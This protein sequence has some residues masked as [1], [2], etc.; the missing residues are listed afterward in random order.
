MNAKELISN[1]NMRP[2]FLS[3]IFLTVALIYVRGDDSDSEATTGGKDSGNFRSWEPSRYKMKHLL[4][5][6]CTCRKKPVTE[7]RW[8]EI[9]F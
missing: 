5:D 3:L 2:I 9:K 1:F 6:L 4:A 7:Q 8:L